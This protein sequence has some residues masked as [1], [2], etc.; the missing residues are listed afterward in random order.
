MRS[1]I[2][3]IVA[4]VFFIIYGLASTVG[5][6]FLVTWGSSSW[7]KSVM[8]FML[9]FPINWDALIVRSLFFLLLNILF[10]TVIVYL[11]A[12]FTQKMIRPQ[13]R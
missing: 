8:N 12:F 13:Q 2:A 11:L 4:V 6:I 1:R 5:S 9:T 10:W 3:I 7:F